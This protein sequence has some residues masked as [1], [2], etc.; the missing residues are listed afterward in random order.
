MKIRYKDIVGEL[1][2]EVY[3]GSCMHCC[4]HSQGCI[5]YDVWQCVSTIF[6]ES[7]SQVFEL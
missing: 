1:A 3:C 4:F 7:K 6:A 2:S 5:P